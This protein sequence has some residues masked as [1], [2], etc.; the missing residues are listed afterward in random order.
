M[1]RPIPSEAT[2]S[3]RNRLREHAI[4]AFRMWAIAGAGAHYKYAE[5]EPSEWMAMHPT[6]FRVSK[7]TAEGL[8][9]LLTE[10]K[11]WVEGAEFEPNPEFGAW[12]RAKRDGAFQQQLRAM[13]S[14]KS[15]MEAHREAWD[16]MTPRQ[17]ASA[18]KRAANALRK[19]ISG[20]R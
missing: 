18:R 6:V 1:T 17:L 2:E 16:G 20:K 3:L 5:P 13:T 8:A 4:M 19:R 14:R 7:K 10:I 12:E 9:R 11:D 15:L